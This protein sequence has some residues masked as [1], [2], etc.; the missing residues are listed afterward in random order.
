MPGPSTCGV[1]P[2]PGRPASI[3]ERP[4][5][6]RDASPGSGDPS[7]LVDGPASSASVASGSSPP[8]S[9]S[10]T[11]SPS[12]SSAENS[13]SS[14]CCGGASTTSSSSMRGSLP[15]GDAIGSSID[16][17]PV[18]A[19]QLVLRTLGLSGT[20]SGSPRTCSQ[21]W[22]PPPPSQ[23]LGRAEKT[24]CQDRRAAP[25]GKVVDGYWGGCS[26]GAPV[27]TSML[28]LSRTSFKCTQSR[29]AETRIRTAGRSPTDERQK[30][31]TRTTPTGKP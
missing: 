5:C 16:I 17:T 10:S 30:I 13:S 28:R 12:P 21:P 15:P 23:K 20:A 4:G 6:S 29:L 9:P 1:S 18:A 19:P 27:S 26:G 2:R 31:N 11:S 25:S 24:S 14:D 3:S 8:S 7:G 22:P